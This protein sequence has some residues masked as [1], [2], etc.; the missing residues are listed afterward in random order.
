MGDGFVWESGQWKHRFG[1]EEQN[2]FMSGIP[3]EEFV[4]AQQ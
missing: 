3:Y 4:E 2:L 1:Q